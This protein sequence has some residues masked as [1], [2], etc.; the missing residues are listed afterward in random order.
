MELAYI[1]IKVSSVHTGYMTLGKS[2]NL[3]DTHFPY[4][5]ERNSNIYLEILEALERIYNFVYVIS[6]TVII[7]F[8][9]VTYGDKMGRWETGD[10]PQELRQLYN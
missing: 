4:L 5:S 10:I 8:F 9:L 2:L 1:S 3:L 6:M 7:T